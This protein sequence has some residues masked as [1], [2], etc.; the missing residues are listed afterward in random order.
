[1]EA[2]SRSSFRIEVTGTGRPAWLVLGQSR[3]RGWAATVDGRPLPEPVLVDGFANGWLLDLADGKVAT[4]ELTWRPQRVVRAGLGASAIGVALCAM[5]IGLS[6]R[7][8]RDTP[9]TWIDDD[10]DLLRPVGDVP[11]VRRA[12]IRVVALAAASLLVVPPVQAAVV[13][14]AGGLALALSPPRR[15][16]A[17]L[18]LVVLAAGALAGAGLYTALLQVRYGYPAGFHWPREFALAHRSAWGGILLLATEAAL[19]RPAPSRGPSRTWQ[20]RQVRAGSEESLK[21]SSRSQQNRN[22]AR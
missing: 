18:A 15:G 21:T 17:R 3:N 20:D 19:G 13:V 9:T 7:R 14:V 4:V 16:W 6:F 8:R 11:H 12:A 22:E 5:L 10:P 1:V 2:P